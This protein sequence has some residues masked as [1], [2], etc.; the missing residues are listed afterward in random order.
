MPISLFCGQ[1]F[2]FTQMGWSSNTLDHFRNHKCHP[3]M[4]LGNHR[5]VGACGG[6][7]KHVPK[8]GAVKAWVAVAVQHVH[9]KLYSVGGRR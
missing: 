9:N 3:L 8:R 5:I 7:I 4:L 6:L 1:G 2:F